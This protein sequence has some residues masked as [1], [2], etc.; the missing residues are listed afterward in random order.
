MNVHQKT[1]S[2]EKAISNH[3]SGLRIEDTFHTAKKV[4]CLLNELMKKKQQWLGINMNSP[5]S[6]PICPGA[7]NPITWGST[8]LE[9]LDKREANSKMKH[10]KM[11]V[12]TETATWP[13]GNSQS[14]RNK[15]RKK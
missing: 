8:D 15:Q 1:F 12:P 5:S 11:M 4:E 7:S 14:L 3:V 2:A 13:L 6:K 10:K 9:I